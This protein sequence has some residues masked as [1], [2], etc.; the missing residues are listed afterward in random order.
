MTEIRQISTSDVHRI[1]SGQVIIDLQSAV[2]ELV[3]NS[4]DAN[5]TRIEITF[6]NYG[7]DSFEVTDNG[8]GI[9]S[10]D[11]SNI[12]LK[13]YT[14]K[15]IKFEDVSGVET[16]GFR[17]EAMS[18]LCSISKLKIKTAT[19]EDYPKANLLEFDHFGNLINQSI[20]SGSKGTSVVVEELFKNLPVRQKNFIKNSKKEFQKV[21]HLLQSYCIICVGVRMMISNVNSKGKK[22]LI[23]ATKE[24][25]SMKQNII[26]VFGNSMLNGLEQLNLPLNIE[27][28]QTLNLK[29]HHNR[30]SFEVVVSGYISS[31][32]FGQGRTSQD[33][34]LVFINNRPVILP[35]LNKLINEVYKTFNHLEYPVF[36]INL[37]IA[38]DLIDINVTPDKRT[39]LISHEN[40]ITFVFREELVSFFQSQNNIIPKSTTTLD[41]SKKA[42][43]FS[44]QNSLNN[45]IKSDST[46]K[47]DK[48]EKEVENN[49]H[50]EN[51]EEQESIEQDFEQEQTNESI[52]HEQ[53]ILQE[54]EQ[55]DD[56]LNNERKDYEESKIQ[57]ESGV[58]DAPRKLRENRIQ[59]VFQ[60]PAKRCRTISLSD[61]INNTDNNTPT[62]DENEDDDDEL[63]NSQPM[64]ISMGDNIIQEHVIKRSKN[65]YDFI[66]ASSPSEEEIDFNNNSESETNDKTQITSPVEEVLD[67]NMEIDE[68]DKNDSISTQEAL[69][70]SQLSRRG[71]SSSN[72]S[73]QT[74][75]FDA[76]VKVNIEEILSSAKKLQNEDLVKNRSN[77]NNKGLQN[78]PIEKNFDED[79]ESSEATLTLTVSKSDFKEMKIVGQ[80]NLG[81]I[82]VTREK[83]PGVVD[84]F[85]ID[86]HA[87]DEKYNFERLQRETVFQSQRLVI[88]ETLELNTLD[89]LMV[90]DNLDIFKLNGYKIKINDDKPN[91]SKVTLISIPL[92]KET[93]FDLQ[94]FQEL[95]HLIRENPSNKAVRPSKIRSMFAMRACR[96]SIMIGKNLSFT[97][98]ERVVKNLSEIDKPWNCP[99]GRPTMRHLMELKDWDNG[100][101][102]DYL[103]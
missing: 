75:N 27:P 71:N 81:F 29:N 60:R 88:P 76:V 8:N 58:K 78:N 22:Q 83:C 103:L 21:I 14:S 44:R 33:R 41:G 51:Q 74:Q 77:N 86:Q 24:N 9:S 62:H 66:E 3:E 2:K 64:T 50:Q 99:H 85:I 89:E 63:S 55:D 80:F 40:S 31:C 15:L 6:K 43:N 87:S 45:F 1:T 61:F 96:S 54:Q 4:L 16:F 10:R 101:I 46:E 25:N 52:D 92:S 100:F 11:F 56:I 95:I 13:H 69:T 65:K 72:R 48:E 20:V 102:S 28:S 30:N 73:Y 42:K 49:Y 53:Q 91:G 59:E 5:S 35:Q 19:N 90:M 94:D 84:L 82:I 12:C 17:G 57:E 36:F 70:S 67:K 34:Q 18:S 97:T 79:E 23:L 47:D 26:D 98:M 68:K 7:I 37:I 93:I 38:P 39:I 32:S